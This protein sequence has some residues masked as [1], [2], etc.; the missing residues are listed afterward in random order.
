MASL[1]GNKPFVLAVV[2]LIFMPCVDRLARLD[3]NAVA[4]KE[5]DSL[6]FILIYATVRKCGVAGEQPI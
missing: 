3:N 2:V 4:A 5:L 6:F 1:A